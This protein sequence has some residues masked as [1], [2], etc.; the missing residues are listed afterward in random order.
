MAPVVSCFHPA[1]VLASFASRSSMTSPTPSWRASAGGDLFL[2][3]VL[4]EA[5]AALPPTDGEAL[6]EAWRLA[7]TQGLLPLAS[8]FVLNHP[9]L[10]WPPTIRDEARRMRDFALFRNVQLMAM[11]GKIQKTLEGGGV[12]WISMKGPVFTEQYAGSPTLR[13]SCDL[14]VLVHPK[15]VLKANSLFRGMGI[16]CKK[17]IRPTTRWLGVQPHEHSYYS[18]APRFLIE[19]HWSLASECYEIVNSEM[20]FRRS[21]IAKVDGGSF[22]VL[23][24]EDTLLFAAMHSLG[25]RWSH[26]YH[27]K[28]LDW[29]LHETRLDQAGQKQARTLDWDYILY[30]AAK[31]RKTRALLLGLLLAREELAAR[32]PVS[33]QQ[34]I[35]S[36]PALPRLR[37]QVARNFL[38]SG[39]EKSS[40][41][42]LFFKWRALESGHDRTGLFLRALVTRLVWRR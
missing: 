2:A 14:D 35:N 39:P 41:Q 10:D 37:A 26:F 24:P 22:P 4:G 27:I 21:R 29:I 34:R 3:I 6:A 25:H 30:A 8:H 33:I 16:T 31:T 19:L 7:K 38:G 5:A 42:T 12:P 20:A 23:S 13:L 9:Q 36:D 1:V 18:A 28:N 11:L 40:W 17:P 15:N 32:L